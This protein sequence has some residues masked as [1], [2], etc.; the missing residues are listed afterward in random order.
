[1]QLFTLTVLCVPITVNPVG[2]ALAEGMFGVAY[3][4]TFTASGGIAPHSFTA[5]PGAIPAGL[6]LA[7]GGGLTG[8]PMNT[9][10]FSFTVTATDVNLC[11]GST[12]YTL[13][14]RPNA[15]PE[16]F[17][18]GVGNTQY[19]VGLAA[20]ATPAV[21]VA[22]SV[23]GNDAGSGALNAGPASI[24]TSANG[25]VAMNPNG[26]FTYT[27]AVGFAGPSDTFTYTLTDGNGMTNTA[28][29]TINLS[30]VVWYVDNTYAGANGPGDGRSHRPFTTLDAAETPS[31]ANQYIFVH[32]GI[33]DTSGGI[34]LD[35]GQTLWGQ[36]TPFTLNGLTVAATGKPTVTGTIVLASDVTVSSLD[37]STDRR[38]GITDPISAITGVIIT[39]AVAITTTRD[40]AVSLSDTGGIL[41]FERITADGAV[42]GISLTNTTGSFTVTGDGASAR[43]DTGGTITNMT[44]NS[45]SLTN[46]ENASFSRMNITDS[47][48]N[49]IFGTDVNGFVVDWCNLATASRAIR[50]GDESNDSIN[51]LVGSGPAGTNPTRI[52]NSLF[53]SLGE[54]AVSIFNTSGPL[55]NTSGPLTELDVTNS[56]FAL[57]GDGSGFLIATRGDAVATV[58][59]TGSTFRNNLACGPA[60]LCARPIQSHSQD[61]CNRCNEHEHV[62][63]Q[64]RRSPVLQPGRC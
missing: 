48:A 18:N 37:V 29:V 23:L 7:S 4:Q 19:V 40:T 24:I 62:F 14:V 8:S 47:G 25:S 21:V 55:T 20:P 27:P 31:L 49:G 50:F 38:P 13:L 32:Q 30:E 6:T 41:A 45:I 56:I 17:A 36:G 63:R 2:P 61:R 10:N 60:R 33:N 9:G 52:T 5:P 39:N 22:G 28:V 64:H 58:I 59:V 51:G 26:T 16:S 53:R 54:R 1:M 57:A 43:N 35:S 15:Q 3:S 44:G 46:V 11:T 34:V 12:A 42:N